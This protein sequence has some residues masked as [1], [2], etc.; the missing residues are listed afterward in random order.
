M[1]EFFYDAHVHLGSL[2]NNEPP[3]YTVDL[4]M[5]YCCLTSAL[6]YAEWTA[7]ENAIDTIKKAVINSNEC[8][9]EEAEKKMPYTFYRA[10]G[11]H[12]LFHTLEDISFL[13]SL[14]EEKK[15]DAVG[16]AG[17]D[18]RGEAGVK[19]G[20]KEEDE[21]E[22]WKE[23]VSA[24]DKYNKTLVVHCVKALD[25]MFQDARKLSRLKA[26]I[27]HAFS[28]SEMDALSL[29]RHG[30]NAYFSFGTNILISSRAARC[31]ANIPLDRLLLESDA[32]CKKGKD[33]LVIKEVYKAAS[34][35]RSMEMDKLSYT[36]KDNFMSAI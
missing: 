27:F 36:V 32:P 8:C 18:R 14:L 1:L 11:L 2:F 23:A 13:Y 28:G 25:V 15:I 6:S 16:E 3:R 33:A 5:Q 35:I 9:K 19:E 24:S 7:Q 12:P 34:T 20:V 21:K 22:F 30:V 4:P 29:L 10:F 31:A 26:V 17:I